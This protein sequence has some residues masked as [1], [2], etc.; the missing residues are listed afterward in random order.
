MINYFKKFYDCCRSSILYINLEL[1]DAKIE[2]ELRCIKIRMKKIPSKNSQIDTYIIIKVKGRRNIE[3][4]GY[5]YFHHCYTNNTKPFPDI[6]LHI[7]ETIIY[8]KYI[9]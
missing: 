3:G 9:S 6:Q 4:D 5:E 1:Y 7:K 8:M 2:R